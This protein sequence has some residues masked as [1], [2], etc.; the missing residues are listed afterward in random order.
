MKFFRQ[1]GLALLVGGVG[2][3]NVDAVGGTGAALEVGVIDS[4]FDR[5]VHSG[6]VGPEDAYTGTEV[7][8]CEGASCERLDFTVDMSPAAFANPNRTGGLQVALRWFGDP[9]TH[10]LPPGVPGCC[11]EFDTLNVYLYKDGVR[12]A[13]SEGIIS[14]SQSLLLESPENGD[15]TAWIVT[16]PS[17]NLNPSVD[18]EAVVEIE[19]RPFRQPVRPLQPNLEFR[20][21]RTVTFDTPSFPLFEPDPAPGE[22]CFESERLEAGAQTCLR[23]DQVIANTGEAAAELRFPLPLDG[24]VDSGTAIQRVYR[25]D[26]SYFD[27]DAGEFEFHDIHQHFHYS[28]FAGATLWVSNAQGDRLGSA[29]IRDGRK[30][31]FCMVD[32]EIDELEVKG[33]GPR[34]YNA[35]DCLFPT[36]FD[37]EHGYIVQGISNGWN[38]I[39]EWYLPDQY[40]EV[41]GVPDGYY[42]LE[43]CADPDGEIAETDEDDNCVANLVHLTNMGTPDRSAE[44]LGVVD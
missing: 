36:Q 8:E 12:V 40:I 21:A 18:Y 26:G 38:D 29:P 4:Y 7:P 15:Y 35:P 3:A 20:S 13:S 6:S 39:Y 28:S 16:D 2:C 22:T 19:Y 10:M 25:S 32:V 11:G 42:R 24:F 1:V 44:N 5:L 23:F 33:D 34:T 27:R 31:S 41:T 9:G 43:N 14:T 37:E 17:Y 30:V